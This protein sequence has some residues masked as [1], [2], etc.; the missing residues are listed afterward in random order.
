M[1]AAFP[2]VELP[3][4]SGVAVRLSEIATSQPLILALSR[5]W[6]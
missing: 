2:D 6:W 3:N 5:G 1:G 4:E